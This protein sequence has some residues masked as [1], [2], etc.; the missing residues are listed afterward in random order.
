[1]HAY[2]AACRTLL[3]DVKGYPLQPSH[4]GTLTAPTSP[5]PQVLHHTLGKA[6]QL[7]FELECFRP[8]TCYQA[9]HVPC[10]HR[11]GSW[12]RHWAALRCCCCCSAGLAAGNVRAHM[13]I[14]PQQY[15]NINNPGPAGP[16]AARGHPSRDGPQAVP[17]A[18]GEAG[19][20]QGA[21]L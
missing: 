1:M 13:G 5:A 19:P 16:A 20:L 15:F 11:R 4:T 7:D 10:M 3:T 12:S 8:V 21:D 2:S 18:E 6:G 17:G 14:H 9:R